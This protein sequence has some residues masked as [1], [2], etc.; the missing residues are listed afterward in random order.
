MA[1]DGSLLES[2][3]EG[4]DGGEVGRA[5]S[6]ERIPSRIGVEAVGRGAF[7]RVV[8]IGEVGMEELRSRGKHL[9]NDRGKEAKRSFAGVEA[10]LIEQRHDTSDQRGACGGSTNQEAGTA[11]IEAAEVLTNSSNIGEG[12]VV[13]VEEVAERQLHPGR[14]IGI[15]GGGLE[16]E[17]RRELREAAPR[18]EASG[19][20]RKGGLFV[21]AGGAR[22]IVHWI[23]ANWRLIGRAGLQSGAR[24]NGC[25]SDRNDI[26]RS[27]RE[28]WSKLLAVVPRSMGS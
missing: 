2:G 12:S 27:S 22:A 1:F 8:S 14:E 3:D 5:N 10:I 18:I 20:G 9:V 6:N 26:G 24:L 17:H 23:R 13:G 7:A 25:G 4:S 11:R 21:V 19:V 15:H 16:R 28:D